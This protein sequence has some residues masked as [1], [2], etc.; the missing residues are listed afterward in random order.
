MW[1]ANAWFV[2]LIFYPWFQILLSLR[3]TLYYTYKGVDNRG[4]EGAKAPPP[5]FLTNIKND[6]YCNTMLYYVR[7]RRKR[8]GKAGS[9]RASLINQLSRVALNHDASWSHEVS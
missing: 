3:G 7:N 2:I 9:A 1:D 8:E 5:R 6:C 4:A